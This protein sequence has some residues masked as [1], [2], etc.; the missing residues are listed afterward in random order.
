MVRQRRGF[1]SR[2]LK[3]G[4]DLKIKGGG[5]TMGPIFSLASQAALS[6]NPSPCDE[7]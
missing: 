6:P 7:Y 3:L 1:S 2:A 4:V 5:G